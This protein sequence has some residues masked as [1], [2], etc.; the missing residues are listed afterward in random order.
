MKEAG[1]IQ[2]LAVDRTKISLS[3]RLLLVPYVFLIYATTLASEL[4]RICLRGEVKV[5]RTRKVELAEVI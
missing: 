4:I 3:S 5:V 2:V 1:L